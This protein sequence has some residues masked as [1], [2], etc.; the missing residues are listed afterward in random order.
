[1][2]HKQASQT[3]NSGR[4]ESTEISV[5][6]FEDTFRTGKYVHI[7]KSLVEIDHSLQLEWETMDKGEKLR[8]LNEVR[9]IQGSLRRAAPA[10]FNEV[11][12]LNVEYAVSCRFLY[13]P[14]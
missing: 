6:Y 14:Y 9:E 5:E 4:S 2:F 10:K 8:L 13:F 7:V 1:M 12:V 11:L 3:Q